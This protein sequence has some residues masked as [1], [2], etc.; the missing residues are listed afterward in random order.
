MYRIGLL[1]WPPLLNSKPTFVTSGVEVAV[2]LQPEDVDGHGGATAGDRAAQDAR[3][4]GIVN[5]ELNVVGESCS[6]QKEKRVVS[7]SDE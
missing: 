4:G 2:F 5:V 1:A 3:A 7:L 6:E